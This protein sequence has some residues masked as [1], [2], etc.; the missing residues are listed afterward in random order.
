MAG[1]GQI[2]KEQSFEENVKTNGLGTLMQE[3]NGKPY[4]RKDIAGLEAMVIKD[5]FNKYNAP[6]ED[7]SD[8]I[9]D[10]VPAG[11]IGGIAAKLFGKKILSSAEEAL[12]KNAIEKAAKSE[13]TLGDE[14]ASAI[15]I[16]QSASKY[17]DE[18]MQ[19]HAGAAEKLG[20]KNTEDMYDDFYN[21][22]DVVDTYTDRAFSKLSDMPNSTREDIVKHSMDSVIEDISKNGKALPRGYQERKNMVL[23]RR[24][25]PLEDRKRGINSPD[26]YADDDFDYDAYYQTDEDYVDDFE[27][28]DDYD[29]Y[30]GTPE[31]RNVDYNEE[32][33]YKEMPAEDQAIIDRARERMFAELGS[34]LK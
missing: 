32:R 20:Y 14:I 18:L 21:K 25:I 28:I 5:K 23:D 2:G 29:K 6:M 19:Y 24:S 27:N 31:S 9:M 34:K 4:D 15:G 33:I 16:K 10:M 26:D 11:L 8:V 12:A 13:K 30:Y 17:P 22:F 7:S 3:V 1:L